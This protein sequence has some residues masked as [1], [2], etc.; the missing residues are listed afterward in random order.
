MRRR[1]EAWVVD[2]CERAAAALRATRSELLPCVYDAV[3]QK[4]FYDVYR[5]CLGGFN[6]MK[7]LG[8]GVGG[9]KRAPD[10]G[11]AGGAGGEGGDDG[12]AG[13]EWDDGLETK[14]VNLVG[15]SAGQTAILMLIDKVRGP[16]PWH[17]PIPMLIAVAPH[18][19]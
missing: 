3:G 10:A 12:G 11:G 19:S 16:S 14:E 13:G 17:S 9:A 1:D 18:Q 2:F 8:A 7:F 5:P 6:G 15:P 4:E